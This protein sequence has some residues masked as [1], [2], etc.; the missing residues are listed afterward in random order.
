MLDV[1]ICLPYN[2]GDGV[3]KVPQLHLVDRLSMFSLVKAPHLDRMGK[4]LDANKK[5][6][7]TLNNFSIFH[8]SRLQ[9]S[10][11]YSVGVSNTQGKSVE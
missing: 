11:Q 8:P 5:L 3:N 9:S 4:Q 6:R 2:F 10:Y 1:I 7:R